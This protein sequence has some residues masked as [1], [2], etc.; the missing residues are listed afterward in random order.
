[1]KIKNSLKFSLQARFILATLLSAAAF[2]V[3]TALL[4]GSFVQVRSNIQAVISGP[5][6][7]ASRSAKLVREL[8]QFTSRLA[9]L[10]AT[11]YG[12]D[13]FLTQEGAV[14]QK[15]L[16][17]YQQAHQES[18]FIE[19]LT[20]LE[21]K[22]LLFLDQCYR[23]NELL[24]MLRAT[25]T[26][27]DDAMVSAETLAKRRLSLP[28]KEV[29]QIITY[30][31]LLFRLSGYRVELLEIIQLNDRRQPREFFMVD[32]SIPMPVWSRLSILK[33]RLRELENAPSPF[34][35][36]GRQMVVQ[37]D[38]YRQQL[39][40]FEKTM[41]LL[42]QRIAEMNQLN[43]DVVRLSEEFDW[44]QEVI[45]EKAR[46]QV[47]TTVYS[48]AISVFAMMTLLV[49]LLGLIQLKLY[50]QHIKAPMSH[51]R[52]RLLKF[53]RGDYDTP[54]QLERTDEWGEIET[55]F[56]RML[57]NLTE[58]WSALQESERRYRDFFD[59]AVEGIF[60]STLEGKLLNMNPAMANMF[61]IDNEAD[62]SLFDNLREL[63]YVDPADRDQLI[64]RLRK[65]EIVSN[66]EVEM[67]RRT[68][69]RFW[70]VING[71]LVRDKNENIL[72]IEGTIE[73]ISQ[74][75]EKDAE[76]VRLKEYLHDIIDTMPTILI[77][78]DENLNISLWNRQVASVSE[79]STDE[80]VGQ[81]LEKKLDLIETT[82]FLTRVR[83]TLETKQVARL[84]KVAG[85]GKGSGHFYDLLFYP[86][87]SQQASGVV[88]HMDDVT[89]KSQIEEV[90]VQSEKMLSV[91]SLAAGMAHEINNPLASVLQNVQVLDQRLSPALKKNR[92]VAEELG[93][94]I[95]QVAEY[96][97]QRGFKKMIESI[98]E[99]GRRAARI[100]ENMLNF[101]RK[102]SSSFLPCSLSELAEKTIELA[103]SD[104][105]MK[106]HFDFRTINV[107]RDYQPIPDVPCESSQVQ[108]VILNLLKN[109]AQAIGNK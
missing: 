8:G 39:D 33:N 85:I 46:Q 27:L 70:S 75:R 19:T 38:V 107:V 97:Q 3:I 12:N 52:E 58:S 32:F 24:E 7:K 54:M 15:I 57:Q 48:I 49:L 84:Q 79:V 25:E 94:T 96:A 109:A 90:M 100:I 26:G 76:L 87:R 73:D 36:L 74:R 35:R 1:M 67:K 59:G 28:A 80:A 22:L 47:D 108:Q 103:A 77:G 99:A 92:Q 31:R 66:Y 51:I 37:L 104:Y 17:H 20:A 72:F 105:D 86:L 43:G 23:V 65:E 106:H 63:I 89:E 60:Q 10:E 5:I 88:I 40:S 16:N 13:S 30:E 61:G 82:T 50:R 62:T 11:F 34:P 81:P 18:D 71:H 93:I 68:G 55:V 91:G 64:D 69:E 41:L 2:V 56:N 9:V 4:L 29:D 21:S 53:Q 98:G 101:S 42:G 45:V 102:S 78:V 6:E 95:E 44:Q 83:Q 14:L